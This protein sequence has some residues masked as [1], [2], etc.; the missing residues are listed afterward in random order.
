LAVHRF[1]F[2]ILNC[3]FY[4]VYFSRRCTFHDGGLYIKYK[5]TATEIPELTGEL[6]N[7]FIERIEVEERTERYSRTAEQAIIIRYRNIGIVG[8]FAESIKKSSQADS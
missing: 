7:L 8:A 3:P 6:L 2:L 5:I 1:G 4:R